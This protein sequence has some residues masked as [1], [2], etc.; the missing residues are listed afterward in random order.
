MPFLYCEPCLNRSVIEGVGELAEPTANARYDAAFANLAST[1]ESVDPSRVSNLG[2]ETEDAISRDLEGIQPAKRDSQ[3][4]HFPGFKREIQWIAARPEHT[5][6]DG[7][8]RLVPKEA[9]L[10]V[11]LRVVTKIAKEALQ[12]KHGS[13]QPKQKSAKESRRFIDPRNGYAV[14]VGDVAHLHSA[15]RRFCPATAF[16]GASHA[17]VVLAGKNVYNGARQRLLYPGE[18]KQGGRTTTCLVNDSRSIRAFLRDR[19]GECPQTSQTGED[20]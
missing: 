19:S 1:S 4:M 10:K 9:A 3:V 5:L 18:I 12:L 20:E 11:L 7:Q 15:P 14:L 2:P 6:R 16:D 8:H 17:Q 13:F